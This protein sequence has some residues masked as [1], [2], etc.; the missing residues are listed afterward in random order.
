MIPNNSISLRLHGRK[1]FSDRFLCNL[2]AND[3]NT[4]E[5][6]TF[7]FPWEYLEVKPVHLTFIICILATISNSFEKKEWQ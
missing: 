6:I 4:L 2:L 1:Q 5:E 7:F 3:D